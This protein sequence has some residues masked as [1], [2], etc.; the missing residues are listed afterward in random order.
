MRIVDLI[1]HHVSLCCC[2]SLDCTYLAAATPQLR[3]GQSSL[4]L[5]AFVTL[6]CC[7]CEC[8]CVCVC[9]CVCACMRVRVPAC[10]HMCCVRVH[11]CAFVN[12]CMHLYCS[13]HPSFVYST[14]SPC[15]RGITPPTIPPVATNLSCTSY[16]NNNGQITYE[17]TFSSGTNC[18]PNNFAAVEYSKCVCTYIVIF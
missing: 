7:M 18:A 3:R 16:S 4:S 10:A 8:V 1:V 17:C 5:N 6:C 2:V 12:L 13:I 11:A 9:V 14:Y 15:C